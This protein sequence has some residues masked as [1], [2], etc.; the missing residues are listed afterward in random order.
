MLFSA[1]PPPTTLHT[2]ALIGHIIGVAFGVGGATATDMVFVRCLRKR[3]IDHTLETVL[4][5]A[6]KLVTAGLVLLTVSGV[7]LLLTG[8]HASPR[9]WAKMVIVIVVAFNGAFAHWL[10]F[11]RLSAAM[12]DG[13]VHLTVPFLNQLSIAA[14]V[15]AVSW[16]AA[17]ILGTWKTASLHFTQYIGV[18]GAVL[19]LA[20]IG[21]LLITPLILRANVFEPVILSSSADDEDR[22][23]VVLDEQGDA[24]VSTPSLGTPDPDTR[25]PNA[26]LFIVADERREASGRR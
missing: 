1:T 19:A 10:T 15:S 3:C 24:D 12:R 21:S 13:E 17:V 23:A 18:Y 11:P 6:S 26:H 14:A 5:L 25:V 16:Y 22:H 2:L 8:T 9:F 20:V 7:A 4:E